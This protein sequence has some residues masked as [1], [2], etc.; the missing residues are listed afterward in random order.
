MRTSFTETVRLF[1]NRRVGVMA[2]LGFSSG[3]PL[4]LTGGT[5]QAWLAVAG[6]DLRTIGIFSL[7][8]LPYA[9]KFLWSPAMDRFVP[10]VLGRRRGWMLGA[11]VS[12]CVSIAAIAVSSPSE[13]SWALG[14]LALTVAFLSASQDIVL[15]AYRA[16]VLHE[17]ERG[18]GA[19]LSVLGY[20]IAMLVSGGFALIFAD[21]MG[22]R[23]TY[24]LMAGLMGVGVAATLVGPEPPKAAPPR[25][26]KEAICEPI[27]EFL[28]RRSAIWML[29][30]IVLYKLGDAFAGTLTTAFLIRGVGFSVAEVGA[31]NKGLGLVALI[32]GALWGGALMAQL[33]LFRSLFIFGILQGVS[34][35]SFMALALTGK[36]YA[37]MVGAVAFEN[38]SGGMGTAAFVALLMTLCN[39]R[40]T[41]T[42]YA[43][44]SAVASVGRVFV[45]PPSGFLVEWVGWAQFF[46]FTTAASL[47]GLWLLW[48]TRRHISSL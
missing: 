38:V 20:R 47:P 15:D 40:Y 41:A 18:I 27:K 43:L 42:Q 23:E 16:D 26:L 12:L 19:G 1:A 45:G 33:G 17:P 24:F 46:F 29:L 32:L 11:Q 10:P 36:S 21:L 14:I 13:A 34:N 39:K 7:A 30:L 4:A 8:G 5:L 31:I 48:N 44:F 6:V 35:L 9:L 22:W 2:F 37:M 25:S 3:L 28:S